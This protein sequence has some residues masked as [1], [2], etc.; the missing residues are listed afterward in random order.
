M[1][2]VM[3]PELLKVMIILLEQH[4]PPLISAQIRKK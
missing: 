3:V 4:L 1:D 2:F